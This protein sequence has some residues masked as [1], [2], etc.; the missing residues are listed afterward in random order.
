M[1]TAADIERCVGSLMQLAR[2]LVDGKITP[3]EVEGP[4]VDQCRELFA[5]VAGPRDPLW[6]LQVAVARKVI[7]LDGIPVAELAEWVAV[8]GG[9]DEPEAPAVSWIEQ[10]LAA[11]ADD[12]D[13]DEGLSQI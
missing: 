9:D 6:E 3:A 8:L 11:G 7:G 13:N 10:A 2:D 1:T 12:E 4:A 5:H